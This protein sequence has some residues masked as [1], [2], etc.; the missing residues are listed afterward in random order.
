MLGLARDVASRDSIVER[1]RQSDHLEG[2]MASAFA[3]DHLTALDSNAVAEK[4]EAVVTRGHWSRD[5]VRR[6]L[7]SPNAPLREVIARLRGRAR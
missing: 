3:L 6:I 1:L 7:S 5:T 2:L 4:L